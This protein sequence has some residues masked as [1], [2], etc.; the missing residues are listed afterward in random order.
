MGSSIVSDLA[1]VIS[2]VDMIQCHFHSDLQP[3]L[4]LSQQQ[5]IRT[6]F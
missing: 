4:Y 2:S 5:R 1:D 3:R 6:V